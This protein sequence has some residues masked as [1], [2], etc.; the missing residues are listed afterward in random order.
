[1][2]SLREFLI[3]PPIPTRRLASERLSKFRALAAFSPDALSSVAYANQEIYLGLVVAG[4]AGLAFAWPIALGIGVLLG[5]LAL[6]YSQTIH[7]YPSG[8]GSYTVARENL[9]TNWGLIAAAALLID[10]VLTAAVSLT[11]GVAAIASAFPILWPWRVELAL[12]ILV[13]IT[14]AN[15]RGIRESGALMTVPV[16]LFLVTFL[17]MIAVGLVRAAFVDPAGSLAVAAPPA[18]LPLSLFLVMHTFASGCTAL[19]GIEAISNGVPAF[20]PPESRN[21]DRTLRVMAILMGA[22]F[23]G[24]IFLTQHFAVIAGPN[25]TILSALAR[26]VLGGGPL[27]YVVQAA[28]LLVL[29]VAANTSFAGFPRVT[30]ILARDGFLP[31]PLSQLGDRLVYSNGMLLLASLS[32]VLIVVFRGD[33]HL[34]IPLFAVGV[35]LAFSLSQA[36]MVVHWVRQHGP[37]WPLKAVIN[38][39]GAATTIIT[40]GIVGVSKFLDGAWIVILLIPILVFVFFTIR[41]HYRETR[42]ELALP[43]APQAGALPPPPRV[44]LPISGVHRGILEALD[45]ALSISRDVTAVYIEIHPG[46]A[47]RIRD[48]WKDWGRDVP[49]KVLDSPYR[50]IVDPL[51]DYLDALDGQLAQG[52]QVVIIVPEFI[53]ARWWQFW[54]HNQTAWLIKLALLYRRRRHGHGRVIVDIPFYLR[55]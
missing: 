55:R 47:R 9:G 27:Y 24:S 45:F 15:L 7:A 39:L 33:S 2:R 6:S 49:L 42:K 46:D 8:G 10:Y 4:A 22:L 17:G 21:A 13:I 3:G 29:A 5:V 30:S 34:L 28:T 54:L 26:R 20:K 35:F 37:R 53:P 52:Q 36:G 19:T 43:A 51:M 18:S 44:I 48:T 41:G 50:S 32:G 14:V 31:H 23:L 38:G 16:Y 12:L 11:A 40:L 25:E 1:M